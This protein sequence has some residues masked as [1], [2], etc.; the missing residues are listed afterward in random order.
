MEEWIRQSNLI[1]DVDEEEE[2]IRSLAAWNWVKDRP[3]TVSNILRL[4]KRIMWKKL[5]ADAGCF[6]TCRV[7]VG[8]REG[9]P[10]AHVPELVAQWVRVNGLRPHKQE[11]I[12]INL[13]HVEFE[14]IHPFVDG[15]GRTGR[16]I[17]N[18]QRR[19]AGYEPL[20]IRA[21]D[22][23]MYYMWFR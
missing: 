7:W 15:N 13:A 17:L 20:C 3:L 1:E 2:D 23:H 11:E 14:R 5:G 4:H 9:A 8:E 22:R 18:W 21:V 6:R 12:E 16:I 19:K 10:W